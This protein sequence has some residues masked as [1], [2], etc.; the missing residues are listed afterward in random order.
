MTLYKALL[1]VCIQWTW[2]KLKS[3][4]FK[5]YT[6]IRF[7]SWTCHR[8]L[9]SLIYQGTLYKV[10]DGIKVCM[11]KYKYIIGILFTTKWWPIIKSG[12][13][14]PGITFYNVHSMTCVKSTTDNIRLRKWS[15]IHFE[16]LMTVSQLKPCTIIWLQK[17]TLG[18]V[19]MSNYC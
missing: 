17:T 11:Y 4:P 19:L 12:K 8:H 5:S 7:E 10:C 13:F 9:R 16:Q 1:S 3:W 15:H 2:L 6:C 18:C 14:S